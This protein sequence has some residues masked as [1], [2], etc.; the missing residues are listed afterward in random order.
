M[1]KRVKTGKPPGRPSALTEAVR[2]EILERLSEGESL[3]SICHDDHMP[4]IPSVFRFLAA[5]GMDQDQ[6]RKSYARARDCQ[7]DVMAESILDIADDARNDWM[8]KKAKDGSTFMAVDHEHIQRS[9]ERIDARKW[10]AAKL[11]P[12]KY[13]DKTIVSG[14]PDAPLTTHAMSE[15]KF[16]EIAKRMVDEL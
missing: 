12:K 8:E 13:G 10:L 9:K 5:D 1:V 15:E 11:K 14:D 3:T 4:S 16:A 2:D 6:F 7:A